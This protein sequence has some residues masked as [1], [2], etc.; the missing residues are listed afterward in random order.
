MKTQTG[1]IRT[2]VENIFPIIKKYLYSDQE[3]F[4][5]ELVSNAVDATQ[6][7]KTLASKGEFKGDLGDTKI[8]IKVDAEA[9]TLTIS[10]KGIGMTLEEL[11]KYINQIAFS[12]AQEFIDKYEDESKIIGHFGL[13]FYSAFMVADKVEINTLSHK[14]EQE[15]VHWSCTGSTS[16]EISTGTRTER[17]T[18]IVLHISEDAKDYLE[19]SQVN[20]LL[21]KYCKFLPVEIKFGEDEITNKEEDGTETVE[22]KDIIINNP[23]PAWT[24]KP[25]DLTDEDYISFYNELYP[26]QQPPLFWIHLNVDYPFN[27]TGILY[28]P[29]ITSNLDIKKN[30][31]GLYC[32]QVFVTDHVD[33][34]V[35]EYLTLLH[36]VLD[37]PDIPLNV[38]RSYLQSDPNVKRI[39]GHISKKVASKLEEIFKNKRD[40]FESKWDDIALFIKY[41]S[42]SD[43]KFAERSK[44]FLL[45]KNLE[46]KYATCEE[47]SEK[48]KALQTDKDGKIVWLYTYHPEAHDTYIANAKEKGYD[49]LLMEHPIDQHFV[50]HLERQNEGVLLKRVDSG[51]ADTLIEKE[52]ETET[53]LTEDQQKTLM[54]LFTKNVKNDTIEIE[55]RSMSPNDLPSIITKNEQMRRFQE[56]AEYNGSANNPMMAS[57]L[58]K[59]YSLVINTNHPMVTQLVEESEGEKQEA[60]IKQLHDLAL[61][62][63]NMLTGS[64]LTAFIKRSVNLMK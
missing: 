29:K 30:K 53:I 9:K 10:D 14:E 5:R 31:I 19:E 46:G 43:E 12:S 56:M 38:S 13:G 49:V 22:I 63:Q 25:A 17:G 24:K 6:K 61:L 58:G 15:S 2:D 23:N 59:R 60:L 26:Y 16:Y 64:D 7:L 4:L 39:N 44:K 45:L 54:D 52:E 42:L 33:E 34:I 62:S 41:G 51:T 3:I 40:E 50:E 27:L 21:N 47:Y 1:T 37:S 55:Y 48:V 35:P 11:D 57:M 28:F 8:E 20:F 36:G 18:D 32:N